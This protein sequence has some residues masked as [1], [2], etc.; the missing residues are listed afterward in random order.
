[1]KLSVKAV[2]E[3]AFNELGIHRVEASVLVDNEK[4]KSVLRACGFKE[5][6]LNEKYLFIN[7]MWRDH[8]TFYKV[9]E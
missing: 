8:I 7:G 3:Y 4:S 5:L 6:G 2:L 1:M 9:N